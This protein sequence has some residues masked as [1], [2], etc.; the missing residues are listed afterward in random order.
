MTELSSIEVTKK[1]REFAL[2]VFPPRGTHD[3]DPRLEELLD[4]TFS[5][6]FIVLR[7][8]LLTELTRSY[9]AG[10]YAG[11]KDAAL[12]SKRFKEVGMDAQRDAEEL[13]RRRMLN[14]QVFNQ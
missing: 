9:V 11:R 3:S 13:E 6:E 2:S 4:L 14:A 1:G 7:D 12:P 10:Y 5:R 8:R